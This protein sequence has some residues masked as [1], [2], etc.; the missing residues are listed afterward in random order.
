MGSLQDAVASGNIGEVEVRINM[1]E[2]VNDS[3]P[4]RY[5]TCLHAAVL[6]NN[7]EMVEVLVRRGAQLN[8]ADREGVTPLALALSLDYRALASILSS[9]GGSSTPS[10]VPVLDIKH[11]PI[12]SHPPPWAK[13][14]KIYAVLKQK[15]NPPQ[16]GFQVKKFDFKLFDKKEEKREEKKVEENIYDT[17]K[18][19]TKKTTTESTNDDQILN[20]NVTGNSSKYISSDVVTSPG[21]EHIYDHVK[22]CDTIQVVPDETE[23]ETNPDVNQENLPTKVKTASERWFE[24]SHQKGKQLKGKIMLTIFPKSRNTNE[25]NTETDDGHCRGENSL[26]RRFMRRCKSSR[27]LQ[28]TRERLS[29]VKITRPNNW[30]DF[31]SVGS[32]LSF[33]LKEN[34]EDT[35]QTEGKSLVKNIIAKV[36]TSVKRSGKKENPKL[37]SLKNRLSNVSW[38]KKNNGDNLENNKLTILKSKI[39]VAQ[40]KMG[41][42]KSKVPS[43]RRQKPDEENK[44]KTNESHKNKRFNLSKFKLFDRVKSDNNP[45]KLLNSF[46]IKQ[47][48][49]AVKNSKE[50]SKT[51][52]EPKY[53][54]VKSVREKKTRFS[55]EISEDF[56]KFSSLQSQ[57]GSR[58]SS[59]VG[60][61]TRYD[62]VSNGSDSSKYNWNYIDGQWIKSDY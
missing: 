12:L 41:N 49:S 14:D 38:V 23:L 27:I 32:K 43:L 11:D 56:S 36:N 22:N 59:R 51:D 2:D 13:P 52:R 45:K 33:K 7:Q 47:K 55:D 40:E 29:S 16:N 3:F 21:V 39:S 17:I 58:S 61:N 1:G 5:L 9:A 42:L 30:K 25:A 8:Q 54:T 48:W 35:K 44:L 57:K 37:T 34:K 28:S 50:F 60:K 18:K 31:N 15:P 10:V 24:K 19:F 26:V 53:S 6:G 62:C 46:N 4:P 20:K